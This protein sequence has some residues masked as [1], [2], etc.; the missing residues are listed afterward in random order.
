MWEFYLASA[1][2]AFRYGA[3]MNFQMQLARKVS[4]VPITRDYML[5]AER[6]LAEP[7]RDHA[8]E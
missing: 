2:L 5:D 8:A 7:A 6:A 1:E 3:H 4:A